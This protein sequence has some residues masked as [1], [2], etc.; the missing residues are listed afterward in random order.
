MVAVDNTFLSPFLQNPLKLGADI[1]MHST[2]K[3]IN[4]HSDVIG[5]ALTNNQKILSKLNFWANALGIT[6]SPFDS[7]LTLGGLELLVSR[8]EKHEK[9]AAAIVDLLSTHPKINKFIIRFYKSPITS[10][11]KKQQNG[12]GGMLSFEILGDLRVKNF[13][14]G[15]N[16]LPLAASLGGLRAL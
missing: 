15:M 16:I 12:F 4:G 1:V 6:G 9:N 10:I 5:G 14:E 13:I 7:Y 3:Y 11:A 8:M 2:T